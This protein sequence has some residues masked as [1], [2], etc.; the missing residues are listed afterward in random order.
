MI[1]RWALSTAIEFHAFSV[2]TNHVIIDP[3]ALS[4]AIEFHA[5]SV[6]HPHPLAGRH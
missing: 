1:D 6:R 5:F 3:W 2:K 4:T